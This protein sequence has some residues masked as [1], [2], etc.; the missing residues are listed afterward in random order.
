LREWLK[1]HEEHE[2]DPSLHGTI[3]EQR[4]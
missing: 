1:A 3:K 4:R 2:L